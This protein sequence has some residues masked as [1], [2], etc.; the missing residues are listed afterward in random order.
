[1]KKLILP[2]L[3]ILSLTG[4]V[5]TQN[6]ANVNVKSISPYVTQ[7]AQTAVPLVLA[8]NRSYAPV[9]SAVATAIPAA[10]ATG[11]LDA[12]SV[13][14]T[15]V[16]LGNKYHMSAEA[17]SVLATALLDGVTWYEQTYGVQVASTTDANVEVLLNAFALGLQ[18]G[19]TTWQNSQ[20]K[21]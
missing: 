21:S 9:I 16:L 4:C 13:S 7:A 15:I 11:N 1:M 2:L 17:E 14:N 12:N 10:F 20:P 6:T 3:L 5:T 18:N 8:K 19:V